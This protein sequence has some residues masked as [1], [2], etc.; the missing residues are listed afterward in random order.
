MST[1]KTRST[2]AT[3][4]G[5]LAPKLPDNPET[6]R[7]PRPGQV[8][9]WWSANRAFWNSLILPTARNGWNPP[10]RSRIV[11]QAGARKAVRFIFW[12]SAAEYFKRIDE[13]TEKELAALRASGGKFQEQE[14]A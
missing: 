2:P 4:V 13:Q 12:S 5:A 3:V 6:F 14:S 10:V 11:R 9:P 7:L 8:D 1:L